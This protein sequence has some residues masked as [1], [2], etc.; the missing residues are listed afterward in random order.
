M[1]MWRRLRETLVGHVRAQ[2]AVY[3]L[4]CLAFAAGVTGGGLSARLLDETHLRDL[5]QY[6]LA[7]LITWPDG[8]R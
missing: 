3:V 5:T 7:F 2:L 1:L 6:F 4:V 8:N